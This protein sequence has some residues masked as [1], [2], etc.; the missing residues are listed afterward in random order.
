ML[1]SAD[2]G[3]LPTLDADGDGTR[4]TDATG[5]GDAGSC[6][7]F[8][9]TRGRRALALLLRDDPRAEKPT[10]P[11]T[12]I[13]EYG[14]SGAS[15]MTGDPEGSSWSSG[16]RPGVER[17]GVRVALPAPRS[18]ERDV[19]GVLAPPTLAMGDFEG[20]DFSG[21]CARVRVAS[22]R[23]VRARG[24][25]D[26]TATGS[27]AVTERCV[28]GAGAAR[29]LRTAATAPPDGAPHPPPI[30]FFAGTFN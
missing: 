9:A 3:R 28:A 21:V 15:G 2:D 14:E 4:A 25:T 23:G 18:T 24:L 19:V 20:E 13:A 10:P 16:E 22:D 29:V 6:S 17:R 11:P 30:F 26:A 5:G 27:V 12:L 8:G 1:A 7:S